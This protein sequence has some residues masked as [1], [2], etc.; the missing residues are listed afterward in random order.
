[1]PYT[2]FYYT[3]LLMPIRRHASYYLR[4]I[5]CCR[6]VGFTP[7]DADNRAFLSTPLRRHYANIIIRHCR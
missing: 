5:Y 7:P 2:P 4:C 1:M 3:L 6:E